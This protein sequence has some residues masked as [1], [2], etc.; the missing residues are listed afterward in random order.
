MPAEAFHP[1]SFL[2]DE[3]VERRL[4][5]AQFAELSGLHLNTVIEILEGSLAV[6]PHCAFD[7]GKAL[8]TSA[9]LWLNLQKAYDHWREH[10]AKK[11]RV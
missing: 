6:N 4:S 11:N 9:E 5:A 7:L 1:G 3:L 2:H 10:K 8:G